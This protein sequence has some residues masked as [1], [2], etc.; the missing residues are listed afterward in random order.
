MKGGTGGFERELGGI[1]RVKMPLFWD[2]TRKIAL[3]R[4]SLCLTSSSFKTPVF[5]CGPCG[6]EGSY[7]IYDPKPE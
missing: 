4:Y 2:E 3:L 1:K 5:F 6:K 7:L